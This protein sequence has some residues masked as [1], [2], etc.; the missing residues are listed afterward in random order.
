MHLCL[1]PLNCIRHKSPLGMLVII[2]SL[3]TLLFAYSWTLYCKLCKLGAFIFPYFTAG[4]RGIEGSN[5]LSK[6]T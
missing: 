1:K 4:N 5:T 2:C 3:F 6:I